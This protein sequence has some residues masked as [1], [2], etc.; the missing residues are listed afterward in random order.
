[1]WKYVLQNP[2]YIVVVI[3]NIGVVVLV[4]KALFSGNDNDDDSDDDNDGGSPVEDP[5]LDLPPG[6]SLPREPSESVLR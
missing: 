1:M 6:V 2:L 5:D 3:L 4:I